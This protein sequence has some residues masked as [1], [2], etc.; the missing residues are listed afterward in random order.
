MDQ[1]R[2]CLSKSVRL[3]VAFTLVTLLAGAA[4]VGKSIEPTAVKMTEAAQQFLQQ[5]SADQRSQAVFPFDSAERFAWHFVPLQTQDKQPRR[6]GVRLEVM[7]ESQK[8]AALDLIRSGLSDSGFEKIK[9]IFSLEDVLR[10]QEKG[11]NVRNPGWYFLT[12]YGQPS[13]SEQWGWRVDGHHVALNFTLNQGHVT[14]VTPAFFGSN[15]AEVKEGHKQGTRPLGQ[16][17]DLAGALVQSLTEEQKSKAKQVTNFPEVQGQT[18]AAK[19]GEPVGVNYAQL[20]P[21][22]QATV[23]KLLDEYLDQFAFDLA[24][25]ERLRVQEVG[26]DKLSFAY[27]GAFEKGEAVTY[28]IQGPNLLVEFLNVQPDGAGNKNNHYHSSWRSLPMDFGLVNGNK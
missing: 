10:E 8:N 26:Y 9:T 19:V 6:K 14:S 17:F 1:Q 7:N 24:L 27:S 18:K 16:R 3:L 12:I 22:Q 15:P 4:L 2:W 5:L 25:A 13:M 11:G 21:A 20:Q 23:R 28:R